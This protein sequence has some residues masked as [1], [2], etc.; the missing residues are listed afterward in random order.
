MRIDCIFENILQEKGKETRNLMADR[1]YT[2]DIFPRNRW[3]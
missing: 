1:E 2:K 3:Q